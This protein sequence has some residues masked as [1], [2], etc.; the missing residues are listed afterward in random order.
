MTAGRRL[1]TVAYSDAHVTAYPV[2]ADAAGR[3]RLEHLLSELRGLGRVAAYGF[4]L[5]L[6]WLTVESA[7]D[8]IA[9][10]VG[11]MTVEAAAASPPRTPEPRP[12]WLMPVWPFDHLRNG[13]PATT[14]DFLGATLELSAAPCRD[15]EGGVQLPAHRGRWYISART[16][17]SPDQ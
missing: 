1:V 8:A 11:R 16:I 14:A 3:G 13:M 9:G 15:E 10:V 2:D 5:S 7:T 4:Q 12:A 17:G 6:P